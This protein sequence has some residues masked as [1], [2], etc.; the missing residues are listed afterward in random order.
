M[1]QALAEVGAYDDLVAALRAR[2]EAL[3]VSR[4]TLDEVAGLPSRYSSKL[5]SPNPIRSLGRVSLGAMLGALGVKLVLMEDGEAMEK[6][7]SRL[8]K[9]TRH[10]SRVQA[11]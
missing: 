7:R 3:N 6:I 9:R 1:A 5:L 8:V 4:E 10:R 2:A 11:P